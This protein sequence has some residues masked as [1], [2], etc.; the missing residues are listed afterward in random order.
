[1]R[2]ALIRLKL[3][4]NKNKIKKSRTVLFGSLFFS[5]SFDNLF[6]SFMLELNGI[7]AVG[8]EMKT[9]Y[10]DVYF[11][12]NF[13]VD[14]FALGIALYFMKIKCST[15]RLVFAGAV[16]A[17]Y[18]VL[19]ILLADVKFIMP[20]LTVLLFF[21]MVVIVT[22]GASWVRKLKY[23][24]AFLMSEIVIGGLVY[25][26]FCMLDIIMEK[27]NVNGGEAENRNL[28]IW[29]VILLLSYGVVKLLMHLFG[30]ISSIRT[31]KVCVGFDGREESF[32]ALVDTGN[33]A[34]DPSGKRPVVFI[35]HELA[36]K[37]LG[38]SFDFSSDIVNAPPDIKKRIRIIPVNSGEEK[39]I[40]YGFL[41][42]YVT[43]V[44]DR[45]YENV[46]V[47][48]AVD[49]KGDLYGG[50]SALFPATAIDNVF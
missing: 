40:L 4:L 49:K 26:G 34:F 14:L 20:I 41:T 43:V 36:V 2:L 39:K 32:D 12:I 24:V 27:T 31:V 23:G 9:L 18:A 11:L 45:R 8:N 1:M 30:S 3:L 15:P 22:K 7:K 50:Y 5:P 35:T 46:S 48:F 37:I 19:G 29:A 47:S 17:A 42:D 38:K 6:S 21:L 13:C 28:L 10:I 25:Y 16:G 33:L 44:K